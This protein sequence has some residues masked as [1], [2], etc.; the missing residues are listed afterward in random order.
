MHRQPHIQ[1]THNAFHHNKCH[2]QMHT[3]EWMMST[4]CPA[5]WGLGHITAQHRKTDHFSHE[6]CMT[7]IKENWIEK[8]NG[9]WKFYF[10]TEK[11]KFSQWQC[12][13]H[14]AKLMSEC[15]NSATHPTVVHRQFKQFVFILY[16]CFTLCMENVSFRS[17]EMYLY[18]EGHKMWCEPAWRVRWFAKKLRKHAFSVCECGWQ[19]PGQAPPK[20]S[21]SGT[22]TCSVM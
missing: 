19:C 1:H 8:A 15:S 21:V 4:R 13:M 22:H 16:I 2:A 6:S 3:N 10:C 7:D 5:V 11:E 18:F 12:T 14:I 17:Y 20:L 9:S